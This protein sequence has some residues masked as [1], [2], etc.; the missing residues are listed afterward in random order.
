MFPP[1]AESWRDEY[2][3]KWQTLWKKKNKRKQKNIVAKLWN[4]LPAALEFLFRLSLHFT[5]FWYLL[6]L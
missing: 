4:V 3:P 5:K 1:V 6:F 2:D